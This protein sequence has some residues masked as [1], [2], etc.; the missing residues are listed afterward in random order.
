VLGDINFL[1]GAPDG[2]VDL[3]NAFPADQDWTKDV[4]LLAERTGLD[5][6]LD[7]AAT[8][9]NYLNVKLEP[10]PPIDGR[11][12]WKLRVTVPK[13]SLFTALPADSAVVLTTT[14]PSPRRLRIPV[15]GMAVDRGGPRF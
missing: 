4:V 12:H 1:T 8:T 9:P 10:L 15:R 11:N 7:A 14:G 3:G 2:R 13:G 6:T 5:L